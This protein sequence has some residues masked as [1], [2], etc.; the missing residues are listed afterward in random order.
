MTTKAQY[1]TQA[2]AANPQ[3][4]YRTVNGE[5]IELTDDEYEASIEA[6]A[7]MRVEQDAAEAQAQAALATKRSAYK[8]LGL[9]DQEI[10]A[11]IGV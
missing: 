10:D 4:Q 7:E 1:M 8:K 3:P 6:W 2:R 11:L 5:Q 9:T